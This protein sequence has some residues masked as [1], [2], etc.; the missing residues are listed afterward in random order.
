MYAKDNQITDISGLKNTTQLTEVGLRGNQITDISPLAKNTANLKNVLLADNQISDLSPIYGCPNL[1][2][3]TI[4]NN[5]ITD[6]K[7]A[8]G[9]SA[10][11]YL[12]AYGNQITDISGLSDCPSIAYLDLGENQITDITALSACTLSSQALFLQN[13]S[14]TDISSLP[15]TVTRYEPLSLYGNPIT[16]YESLSSMSDIN[17][18]WSILAVSWDQNWDY[19]QIA[20]S[21]FENLYLVDVPI[22]QQANVKVTNKTIKKEKN[23]YI[24]SDPN[25]CSKA[26]IDAQMA[27]IRDDARENEATVIQ[28]INV[29]DYF[30]S[31]G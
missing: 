15:T 31:L 29:S 3:L 5:Q 28:G 26:E 8:E 30:A 4:E 17:H 13:N 25:F 22:D 20:R 18:V 21:E 6:L 12:T 24:T 10:L 16:S 14:I 23:N 2:V 7:V 1:S 19:E 11:R 9:A 27:E